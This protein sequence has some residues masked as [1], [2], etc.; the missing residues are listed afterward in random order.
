MD[1]RWCQVDRFPAK[2][3]AQTRL[4]GCFL[5][6]FEAP[7]ASE[8]HIG[9]PSSWALLAEWFGFLLYRF[10]GF[11]GSWYLKAFSGSGLSRHRCVLVRSLPRTRARSK[12]R[13]TPLQG[14]HLSPGTSISR[15]KPQKPE[16]SKR[17]PI[18]AI[19][20]Y[21]LQLQVK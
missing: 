4:L 10:Y 12:L 9:S 8:A 6:G 3:I 5:Y 21:C 14:F 16:L 13:S 7:G 2:D 19:G 20:I 11:W 1:F 15:R 18:F 17:I